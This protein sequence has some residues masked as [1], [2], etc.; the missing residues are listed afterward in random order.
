M[1]VKHRMHP[2]TS[3]TAIP[4]RLR[5]LRSDRAIPVAIA[6]VAEVTIAITAVAPTTFPAATRTQGVVQTHFLQRRSQQTRID[7]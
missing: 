4:P 2:L 5:A 7:S 3:A 6:I 1:Y